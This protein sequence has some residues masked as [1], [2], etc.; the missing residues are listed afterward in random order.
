MDST[1]FDDLMSPV[2]EQSET[3]THFSTYSEKSNVMLPLEAG[4]NKQE[5]EEENLMLESKR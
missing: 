1:L 3:S 2:P 4:A 5:E